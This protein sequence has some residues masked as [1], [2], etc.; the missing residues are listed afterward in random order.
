MD[1]DVFKD[2]KPTGYFCRGC[3]IDLPKFRK[4]CDHCRPVGANFAP[5]IP[6]SDLRVCKNCGNPRPAGGVFPSEYRR[7]TFCSFQCSVEA[8]PEVS[9]A[10]KERFKQMV[11][12]GEPKPRAGTSDAD[13]F[14]RYTIRSSDRYDAEFDEWMMLHGAHW[15]PIKSGQVKGQ[16]DAIKDHLKQMVLRGEPRPSSRSF[17]GKRLQHYTTRGGTSYEEDFD[18]WMIEN[19]R[20]WF[21]RKLGASKLDQ[22]RF[23]RLALSGVPR[24][25]W[26]SDDGR[27][28]TYLLNRVPEFGDWMA[29]N[30][31]RWA[32]TLANR[33]K[34]KSKTSKK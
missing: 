24:P 4:W 30:C 26:K 34:I 32:P 10:H 9:R 13:R 5:P 23:Q 31:P 19:A 22:E 27:R 1:L 21:P 33:M 11:L 14:E 6:V 7:V 29:E 3:D 17:Y 28:L 16:T 18:R 25:H 8:R 12:N 2:V 20:E 15:R